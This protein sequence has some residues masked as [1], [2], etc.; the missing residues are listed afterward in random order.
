MKT[1]EEVHDWN[2]IIYKNADGSWVDD[3]NKITVDELWDRWQIKSWPKF[4]E[5]CACHVPVKWAD[6]VRVM[7]DKARD[8]LGDKVEFQQIKEK[9]CRL[10]VYYT[11]KD[12][13]ASNRMQDLIRNCIE[14]LQ[15]KKIYPITKEDY[16]KLIKESG[17][18][19]G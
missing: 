5:G 13:E 8:E 6:D 4:K 1:I 19:N 3:S 17:E 7:L 11:C 12:D 14:Q 2:K 16:A 18:S 10:T 15:I 9:F